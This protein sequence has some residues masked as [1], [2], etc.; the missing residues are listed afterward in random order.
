MDRPSKTLSDKHYRPFTILSK[1]GAAAYKL[2]LPRTWKSI[3]PVFNK[4]SLTPYKEPVYDSQRHPPPPPPG[5]IEDQE[6]YEVNEIHDSKLVCGKLR[7]L[8]ELFGY[9]ERHEWTW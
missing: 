4:L 6:E 3:W 5:I 9:P 8:V 7:Y 2:K 1:I